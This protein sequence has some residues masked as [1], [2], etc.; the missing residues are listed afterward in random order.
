MTAWQLASSRLFLAGFKLYIPH[1]VR[2]MQ[3]LTE[4]VAADPDTGWPGLKVYVK[5]GTSGTGGMG[6]NIPL[7]PRRRKAF[8]HASVQDRCGGC[9]QPLAVPPGPHAPRKRPVIKEIKP[10]AAIGWA[11]IDYGPIRRR[12]NPIPLYDCPPEQAYPA[13]MAATP[14]GEY[15]VTLPDQVL[16]NVYIDTFE[17]EGARMKS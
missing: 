16:E 3:I 8:L 7:H 11:E 5:V 12:G 4:V 6:L 15:G 1:V 13:E 17:D 9:S 14:S 2:H 10:S